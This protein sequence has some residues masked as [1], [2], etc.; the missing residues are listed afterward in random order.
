MT[1]PAKNDFFDLSDVGFVKRV[2][3]G[4][5]NPNNP[6][7]EEQLEKQM[8][9]LNKCLN[10]PPKGKIIGREISTA[11]YRITEHEISLQRITYHVGFKRKPYWLDEEGEHS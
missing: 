2:S 9:L 8:D 4:N 5:L 7:T 11:L 3:V 1:T 6:L 10:E